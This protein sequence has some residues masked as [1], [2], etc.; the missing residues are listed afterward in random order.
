[1]SGVH[2]AI[3]DVEEKAKVRK[4]TNGVKINILDLPVR[5]FTKNW[6]C[7]IFQGDTIGTQNNT[8][9]TK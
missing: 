9:K 4:N 8:M 7:L 2:F 3:L 6:S 5:L 1:M